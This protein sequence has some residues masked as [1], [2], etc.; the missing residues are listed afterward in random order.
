MNQRRHLTL[1]AAGATLLAALPL[2]TVFDRWTWLID[3]VLAVGVSVGVALTVRSFRVPVWAAT[4]AMSAAFLLLL[5][6]IF[7]SG[8]EIAGIIPTLDTFR[9]FNDLLVSAGQDMRTLGIPVEDRDGLLFLTTLGIGS[10]AIVVDLFAVVLRRPALAGLPMLAIYSVPVAVHQD[11]VNFIPFALGAAGFLWL[12]VTDNV[13]RV[14]RF[15]RRFTGDGRDV[16]L[17][18]PSPLAAAGRRLAVTGVLL[19]VLL[20]LLVPGMTSGLL[21]RYGAGGGPGIGTGKGPPGATVNLFAVLSG[22]LTQNKQFDMVRI[23]TGDPAP[24]YARFGVADDLTPAGFRNRPVSG[25]QALNNLSPPQLPQGNGITEHAFRA[26]VEII[27]FEMP[28]L[29]LYL[30]P[31]RIEKLD[32]SWVYDRNGQILYSPRSSSKGKKY[33][34]D[35]VHVDYSPDAL[36]GATPL[37]PDNPIQRQYTATPPNPRVAAI[38]KDI[39]AGKTTPYDKVRAILDYFSVKNN[40]TYS[41][42]TKSGTSGS[43]IVDFLENKQGFCEQYSAAMAWLARLAGVPARVAFGFTRGTKHV[44]NTYTFTNYNLHAW[45]EVYFDRFG[46][47]PFDPTPASSV[48]GS[49]HPAWGPDPNAPAGGGNTGGESGDLPIG[50][51][52]NA[53]TSAGPAGPRGPDQPDFGGGAGPLSAPPAQWPRWTLLGIGLVL[54][55]LVSP[56]LARGLVRRRRRPERLARL[57]DVT[58]PAPVD[59]P[60][61]ARV[62]VPDEVAL[63]A[64]RRQAHG[65]WDELVDTMVDYR[66]E[67]DESETPRTTAE[68]LV[69]ATE[70]RGPVA[71]GAR[72]LGR[73]EERARYA[74]QPLRSDAL[75]SSLA[76]IRTA[77]RQ[78]VSWRTRLVAT[79]L[80]PS[81]LQRWRE[82][83]VSGTT[84]AVNAMA[85]WRDRMVRVFSPRR[86]LRSGR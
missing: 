73:A 41:L 45:T 47:V 78:R 27:N 63:D 67:L 81:V 69:R 36:R 14:R 48:P 6:W 34:F 25:G 5:T 55:L 44:G 9:N 23:Q 15:G 56:A 26:S 29:P 28:L 74:R 32:S 82:A 71:D 7:P 49:V 77:I 31:T 40:F 57:V 4:A 46:W 38:L 13:E 37:P 60:G 85:G 72:L 75:G 61:Q 79:F 52:P 17:W 65:A 33:N 66:I 53:S 62:F 2:S 64:A 20:P 84:A 39:I 1:V 43:D 12:L 70:L 54:A 58:G 18:E 83:T 50:G 24:F 68:R 35:Y 59:V 11:S 3:A 19:A 30:Q 16:D 42:A 51:G 76:A 21:D 80:P 8:H 86:L 10:V 22:N